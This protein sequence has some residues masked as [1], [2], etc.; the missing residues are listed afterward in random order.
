MWVYVYAWGYFM[1]KELI[2][3][4]LFEWEND[5]SSGAGHNHRDKI[6]QEI[7]GICQPKWISV[8]TELPDFG[9]KVLAYWRP[10]DHKERPYHREII[11]AERTV[12]SEDIEPPSLDST[13]WWSGSGKYYDTETFITHWQYLPEP[14]KQ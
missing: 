8:D 1:N 6:A 12:Y 10:I 14:P 9:V 4:I 2:S 5:I 3:D 11:I 13:N 7:I